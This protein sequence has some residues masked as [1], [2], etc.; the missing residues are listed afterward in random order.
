M[1]VLDVL[2]HLDDPVP[3][4]V[5]PRVPDGLPR[6]PDDREKYRHLGR[7]TLWVPFVQLLTAAAISWSTFRF[8]MHIPFAEIFWVPL[9]VSAVGAILSFVTTIP[10]RRDS[11]WGH[12][13]RVALTDRRSWPSVDVFLPSCGE[14]LSVLGNTFHWV[15]LVRWPG[16]LQV[17]VLDD[18]GRDEVARLSSEFGFIYHSRADRG[19]LKKAGNLQ[20]GFERTDGDLIAVFD[21]DFCPRADFLTELVPYCDE[22][23]VGIVQ[24]PQYFDVDRSMNWVQQCAAANQEYFYRWVQP[25]RDAADAAVCV[26]TNALYRRTALAGI[27]GFAEI[28]HSEDVYTGVHLI[29]AGYR[30]RYVPVILAK[31]LCPD[32]VDP[33]VSQQYRWCV[34]SLSLLFSRQFHTSRMS[35][36]QRLCFW[37]G[38]LYY[39]STALDLLLGILPVMIMGLFFPGRVHAGNY[40]LAASAVL[41]CLLVQPVLTSGRGSLLGLARTQ[42]LCGFAHA[43][44]LWDVVRRRPAGWVPT[45]SSGR[46]GLATRVRS[47]M[48][49]YHLAFQLG[50]WTVFAWRAP[51]YGLGSY[52]PV[53]VVALAHLVVAAPLWRGTWVADGLGRGWAAVPTPWPGRGAAPTTVA[54]VDEVAV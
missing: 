51:Q 6:P 54:P 7:Q 38:F 43:T 47:A 29:A 21:A 15:S 49:G 26:G 41:A 14:D 34:G 37:A 22:P 28:D 30:T 25:A 45:G 35:L 17:H 20:Y 46:G 23:D 3:P 4:P 9:A 12:D 5:A 40:V 48:V 27:G 42:V 24:S 33:F 1:A 13:V 31:G 19:R 32:A 44:A 2:D 39:V 11:E 16:R 36:R 8:V 52:W 50:L 18:S 10:H 53:A